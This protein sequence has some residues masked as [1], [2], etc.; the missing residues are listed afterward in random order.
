MGL[1]MPLQIAL[2]L[3]DHLA[4]GAWES[5]SVLVNIVVVLLQCFSAFEF[6]VA[7]VTREWFV[8]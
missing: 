6:C 1:F 4:R 2:C 5:W 7:N 8:G 3:E